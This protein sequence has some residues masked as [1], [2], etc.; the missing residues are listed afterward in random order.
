MSF[1][2]FLCGKKKLNQIFFHFF[3][4]LFKSPLGGS[5]DNNDGGMWGGRGNLFFGKKMLSAALLAPAET[6]ILMLLSA[7]VERFGVPR[8]R[9]FSIRDSPWQAIPVKKW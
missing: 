2:I 9:D 8:M 5:K 1:V 6:K 4:F 7:S 3:S